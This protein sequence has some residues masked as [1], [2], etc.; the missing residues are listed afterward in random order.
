MHLNKF[1][2]CL[3]IALLLNS[4]S[5]E[6]ETNLSGTKAAQEVDFPLVSSATNI[7]FYEQVGG[8]QYLDRFVRLQVPCSLISNQ[9]EMIVA[10]NNSKLRRSLP[11]TK[12]DLS[13]ATIMR[14]THSKQKLEWWTPEK[15]R[16][17]FYLGEI[18][19]YA[20]Q[21]WVDEETGT[22]YLHQN[23]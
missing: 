2:L 16:I 13:V 5:Q 8:L 4:C 19:A 9:L 6:P 12:K 1:N 22:I 17:G 20:V 3:V 18:E 10:D 21:V 14:P 23:S 7:F 15:I 11:Y